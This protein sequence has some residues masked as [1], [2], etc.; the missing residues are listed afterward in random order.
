MQSKALNN[1]RFRA[2]SMGY[3]D[4]HIRRLKEKDE[5]GNCFYLVSAVEPLSG[6]E[7][8]AVYTYYDFPR[9]CWYGRRAQRAFADLE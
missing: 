9:L 5:Y 2:R 3:K 1:F 6:T 7:V 4:I 8:R